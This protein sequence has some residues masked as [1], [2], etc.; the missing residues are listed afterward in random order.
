MVCGDVGRGKC[1]Y[2]EGAS[3]IHVT[4]CVSG[5]CIGIEQRTSYAV[6]ISESADPAAGGGVSVQAVIGT[7][8]Q[9][10]LAVFLDASYRTVLESFGVR[11]LSWRVLF[12]DADQS[13]H[14]SNPYFPVFRL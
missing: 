13:V 11:K 6:V 12:V 9:V 7:D 5:M 4:G 3:E 10:P 1:F 14:G 2:S 8:P